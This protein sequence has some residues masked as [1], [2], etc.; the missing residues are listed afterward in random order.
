MP[1]PQMLPILISDRVFGEQLRQIDTHKDWTPMANGKSINARPSSSTS[2][3]LRGRTGATR[4]REA[5][6][7]GVLPSLG[8]HI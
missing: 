3:L 1:R 2:R 8:A 4:R 7:V 5:W 6:K